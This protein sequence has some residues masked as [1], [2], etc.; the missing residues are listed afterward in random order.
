[1]T[2]R[3]APFFPSVLVKNVNS[4]ITQGRRR[5]TVYKNSKNSVKRIGAKCSESYSKE[6]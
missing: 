3:S 6:K 5:Q 1:M 4:E 2:Q